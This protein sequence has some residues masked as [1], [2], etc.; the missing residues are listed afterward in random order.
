MNVLIRIILILSLAV[1]ASALH[2]KNLEILWRSNLDNFELLDVYTL[3]DLALIPAGLGGLNILDISNPSSPVVLSEYRAQG[4]DWGRLYAWAANEKY[5]FGAGRECGIHILDISNPKAPSFVGQYSD[6]DHGDLRYEHVEI[7]GK[8]VFLSRHQGGVE[9]VEISS[10]LS[11]RKRSVVSTQNAWTTLAR[12][13][14]L[15]VADGAAG[16]KII[17]ISVHANPVILSSLK[18]SGSAK[19]LAINGDHL[20]VAVGAAGVDMIDISDPE[21]PILLDNHYTGGYASRV[22]AN[23]ERVA[24]SDWEDV[25]ILSHSDQRLKR[26]GYKNTG[27]RVMAIEMVDDIIYSAEWAKL[28]VYQFGAIPQADIDLS[29]RRLDFPRTAS[30]ESDTLSFMLENNGGKT[31]AI[32]V[33][34]IQNTDFTA[35]VGSHEVQGGTSTKVDVIYRPGSG[36]W[37]GELNLRT[38]DPDEP[39]TTVTFSGNHTLGPMIGDPV[40]EFELES[41]N[42]FGSISTETLKGRPVVIA[43]FTAW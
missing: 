12:D 20:F 32:N 7:Q 30:S 11:M 22:S 27:G 43:F 1:G 14:L 23:A 16:I 8:Y 29:A 18:T 15:F 31:L 19:D 4:C 40:P 34:P 13:S 2:G 33:D 25:E 37:R 42:G 41:I 28:T 21:N 24:V 17:D 35:Q 6:P 9:I 10:P 26:V 38:N 39:V 3:N 5:A 36:G